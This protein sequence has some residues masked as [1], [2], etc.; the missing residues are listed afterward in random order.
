MDT[1]TTTSTKTSTSTSTHGLKK[2][3][4]RER[5]EGNKKKRGVIAVK[6]MLLL[7]AV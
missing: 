4:R 6:V 1:S 5:W 3:S 7:T 2:K